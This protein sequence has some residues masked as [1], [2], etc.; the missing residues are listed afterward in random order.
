VGL[1]RDIAKLPAGPQRRYPAE[2]RE[3]IR[4]HATERLREGCSR[5][6]LCRELGVGIPTLTRLLEVP[7]FRPV[8]VTAT[9]NSVAKGDSCTLVFRSRA[10]HEVR[11]LTVDGVARLIEVL[12]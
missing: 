10:G 7:D 9:A 12:G 4:R 6:E 1:V 3:R 8:H 2:L 5:G 11:G